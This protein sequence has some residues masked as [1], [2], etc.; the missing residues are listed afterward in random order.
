MDELL[1]RR[2]S[3]SGV[4][5][6]SIRGPKNPVVD[7]VAVY[8]CTI[9]TKKNLRKLVVK[10]GFHQDPREYAFHL[11]SHSPETEH[12]GIGKAV[13]R[14]PITKSG[15]DLPLTRKVR[16]ITRL[17]QSISWEEKNIKCEKCNPC[18]PYATWRARRLWRSCIE[19]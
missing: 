17:E 8:T 15:V 11:S 18:L 14:E 1:R 13:I 2:M 5:L 10:F 6:L 3:T 12:V 16:K 4:E 7:E 9:S 19:D